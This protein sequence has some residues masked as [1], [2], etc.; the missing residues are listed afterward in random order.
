MTTKIAVIVPV[1]N[2][3]KSIAHFYRRIRAIPLDIKL[4]F[5]DNASTDDTLSIL[6]S[7]EDIILIKHEKNEGYGASICDGIKN[8]TEEIIAI[9][10][11]DCEYPPESLPE[12]I[13]QLEHH[14]VVYASRFLDPN[15]PKMPLLKKLGNALISSL[16]NVLFRQNT[17]DL[18]TGCKVLKRSAMERFSLDKKGFEHVL[19]LAVKLALQGMTIKDVYVQFVP[20]QTDQSKMRH[21]QETAKSIFFMGYYFINQR[22]WKN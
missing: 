1:Y 4:I 5:V 11:V 12:M 13:R 16:Y 17:T 6:E 21:L 3:E 18:Y 8:S 7:L 2:E 19:E 14:D 10:D 22:K 15:H 9:I 20:R